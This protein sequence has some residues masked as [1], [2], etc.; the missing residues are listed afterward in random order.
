MYLQD[1]CECLL[2]DNLL[3]LRPVPGSLGVRRLI[4][5][6]KAMVTSKAKCSH[7]AS[8][9]YKYWHV[10]LLTCHPHKPGSQ[11]MVAT[12]FW[13]PG[14]WGWHVG[15]VTK[16]TEQVKGPRHIDNPVTRFGFASLWKLSYP[17]CCRE[18]LWGPCIWTVTSLVL[19]LWQ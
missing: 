9:E 10:K 16:D 17:L 15:A 13:D 18:E 6:V 8:M 11:N 5:Q 4:S 1:L 19:C 12:V 7:S 2:S 14:V 3:P